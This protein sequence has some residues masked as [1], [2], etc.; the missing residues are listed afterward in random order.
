MTNNLSFIQITIY[1][2]KDRGTGVVVQMDV[3]EKANR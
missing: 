1:R 3:Y 2:Y